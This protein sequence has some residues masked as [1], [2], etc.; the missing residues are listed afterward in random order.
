MKHHVQ[1]PLPSAESILCQSITI[2]KNYSNHEQ[3]K[4]VRYTFIN[5]KIEISECK[6]INVSTQSDEGSA[7]YIVRPAYKYFTVDP[8]I[9]IDNIFFWKCQSE[10]SPGGIFID[11][12]SSNIEINHICGI[13]VTGFF[14]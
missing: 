2:E 7:I 1:V 12:S 13:N 10:T 3:N 5:E 9:K 14:D 8:Q 11:Y 6:F 4:S